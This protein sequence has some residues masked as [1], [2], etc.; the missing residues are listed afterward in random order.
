MADKDEQVNELVSG[1][2]KQFT[3]EE[4]E[5]IERELLEEDDADIDYDPWITC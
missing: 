4:I 3:D 2:R 5:E 1:I